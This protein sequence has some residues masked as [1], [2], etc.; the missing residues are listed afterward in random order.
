M[1]KLQHQD[2]PAKF[3]RDNAVEIYAAKRVGITWLQ[4]RDWMASRGYE[5]ALATVNQTLAKNNRQKEKENEARIEEL[6]KEWR[7]LG[8]VPFMNMDVP[9][10]D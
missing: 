5:T 9:K 2:R 10:N 1:P 3:F 7:E 4:V 6:A 8:R